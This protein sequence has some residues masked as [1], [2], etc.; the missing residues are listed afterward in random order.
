MPFPHRNPMRCAKKLSALYA[1]VMLLCPPSLM[2]SRALAS[3]KYTLDLTDPAIIRSELQAEHECR[4][5]TGGGVGTSAPRIEISLTLEII[6]LEPPLWRLGSSSTVHLRL[7]NAG[8]KP[9]R[10]PWSWDKRTIYTDYCSAVLKSSSAVR[11]EANS[12]LLFAD[13]H[14]KMGLTSLH[15]LYGTLDEPATY[16]LLAPGESAR[17][18]FFAFPGEI[19]VLTGP[20]G[21]AFGFPQDFIVSADYELHDSSLGNPYNK[22]HSTNRIIIRIDKS[23]PQ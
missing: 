9:V 16:R 13:E 21:S 15:A 4:T 23:A 20:P 5:H 2:P 6:S 11:L 22:I 19:F 8:N 10:V 17:I 1:V 14:G 18:K 3:D 7:T 12:E